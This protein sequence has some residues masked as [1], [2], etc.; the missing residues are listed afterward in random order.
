MAGSMDP[1]SVWV[2]RALRQRMPGSLQLEADGE[3]QQP[4]NREQG[5]SLCG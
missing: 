4:S 2:A 1:E 5:R 3:S